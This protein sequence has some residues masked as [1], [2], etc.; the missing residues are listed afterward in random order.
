MAVVGAKRSF[1]HPRG[2]LRTEGAFLA[3]ILVAY[4]WYLSVHY[5]AHNNFSILRLPC[6]NITSTIT[7]LRAE[8]TLSPRSCGIVCS[9]RCSDDAKRAQSTSAG[10]KLRPDFKSPR[11]NVSAL[12]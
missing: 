4:G 3:G 6:S 5:C 8:T 11:H 10:L 12:R 1:A 7:S 9:E 2:H